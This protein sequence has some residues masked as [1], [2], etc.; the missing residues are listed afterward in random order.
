MYTKIPTKYQCLIG[1]TVLIPMSRFFDTIIDVDYWYMNSPIYKSSIGQDPANQYSCSS[2][3][4]NY[5]YSQNVLKK[6]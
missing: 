3:R 2:N 4:V 5:S 1:T 6:S